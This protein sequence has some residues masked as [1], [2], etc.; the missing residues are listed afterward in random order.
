MIPTGSLPRVSVLLPVFN[1]QPQRLTCAI[2]SILRQTLTDFELVIVDDGSDLQPTVSLLDEYARSD[3]RVVLLRG[4]N[5]GIARALNQGLEGCRV[6]AAQKVAFREGTR[7][8]FSTAAT[9]VVLASMARTSPCSDTGPCRG[10][11]PQPA[12]TS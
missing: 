3:R 6:P 10:T 12:F 5:Q 1:E 8:P 7:A 11:Y 4:P 2:D 9:L